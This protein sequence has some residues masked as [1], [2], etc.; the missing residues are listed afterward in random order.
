MGKIRAEKRKLTRLSNKPEFIKSYNHK[1]R[2]HNQKV[3]EQR[4]KDR[5]FEYKVFLGILI[6][7]CTVLGLKLWL[8]G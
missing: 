3:H 2:K 6:A 1:V 5:L 8:K 4:K 7:F